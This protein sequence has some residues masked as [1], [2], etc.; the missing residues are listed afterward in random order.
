MTVAVT[1][2]PTG[3][4]TELETAIHLIASDVTLND[5]SGDEV[6]HYLALTCTG[7]P[8]LRSVVFAGDF[9]WDNVIF[10]GDGSWTA[11]LHDES[12]DSSVTTLA[13]TVAAA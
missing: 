9:T 12:D 6:R 4:V 8:T 7:Q 2:R 13:I 10:P 11:T 3:T 5:S 1:R